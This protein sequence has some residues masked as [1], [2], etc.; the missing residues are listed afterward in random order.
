MIIYI[1]IIICIYIHIYLHVYLYIYIYIYIYICIFISKYIYTYVSSY[2]Y[3]YI[4]IFIS[5]YIYIYMHMYVSLY[6]VC[7]CILLYV[8][9]FHCEIS[10]IAWQGHVHQTSASSIGPPASHPPWWC[11]NWPGFAF[12]FP[13]MVHGL[14]TGIERLSSMVFPWI[15]AAF[16]IQIYTEYGGC[17]KYG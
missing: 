8:S 2:L 4:C 17:I 3:T 7:V 10:H 13:S 11:H 9:E 1:Y 15:D 14:E 6:I 12:A 16:P 5:I